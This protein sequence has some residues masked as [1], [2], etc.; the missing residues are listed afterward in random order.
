MILIVLIVL[1]IVLVSVGKNACRLVVRG[2][3]AKKACRWLIGLIVICKESIG[4][5]VI[6]SGGV[7]LSSKWRVGLIL[8][9]V[10]QV[11]E[12]ACLLGIGVAGVILRIILPKNPGIIIGRLMK[13]IGGIV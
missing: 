7:L 8:S 12:A 3:L 5:R 10:I 9:L 4:G 1:L 13:R 6:G 2:R 11:E